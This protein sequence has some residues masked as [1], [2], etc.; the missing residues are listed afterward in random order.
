MLVTGSRVLDSL[1]EGLILL[2]DSVLLGLDSFDDFILGFRVIGLGG[3]VIGLHC[4]GHVA[5][6]PLNL[7]HLNPGF[8]LWFDFDLWSRALNV[9]GT[10]EASGSSKRCAL[11]ILKT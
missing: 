5:F 11:E 2:I 10:S 6:G 7:S 3:F 8:G 4:I 1:H 9:S